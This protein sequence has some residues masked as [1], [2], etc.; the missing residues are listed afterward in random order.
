MSTRYW[1]HLIKIVPDYPGSEAD[2]EENEMSHNWRVMDIATDPPEVEVFVPGIVVCR[3]CGCLADTNQA[4]YPCGSAPAP[5]SM[6][7]Y[8]RRK[9]SE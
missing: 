9:E 7:E 6:Y 4:R 3:D 2:A 5:M 8:L 1:K